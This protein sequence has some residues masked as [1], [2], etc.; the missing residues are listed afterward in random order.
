MLKPRRTLKLSA[1]A[2]EQLSDEQLIAAFVDKHNTE[3]FGVLF[4]RYTH[5]VFGLCLK[6]LKKLM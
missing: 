1:A 6:Y 2:S 3:Y 5:L 4:E